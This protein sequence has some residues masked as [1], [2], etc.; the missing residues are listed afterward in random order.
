MRFKYTARDTKGGKSQ[1][2]IDAS[3]LKA[4]LASLREMG[5]LPI[6]IVAQGQGLDVMNLSFGKKNA[7]RKDVTNFTRQLATMITAGLPLTDALNLLKLQSSPAMSAIV[8]AILADVQGGVALSESMARHPEVFSTIYVA[9]IRAGEAGGV[10]ETVLNRLAENME[11]SREF[12]GKVKGAM[13]Y[14]VIVLAGMVAVMV[15]MMVFVVPKITTLYGEFNAQLPWSTKLVI[16]VS[17]FLIKFWWLAGMMVAGLVGGVRFLLNSPEG[18]TW[19][20]GIFYRIPVAGTL[21]KEMML[22][23]LTRT[24]SLLIGAGVAIVDALTISAGAVG[25]VVT[26]RAV[27]AIAKQV[28]RGFPVSISFSESPI[29]PSIL[30]QILA[31]GEETGKMDEVLIK[32][33]HYFEMDA[34]EKVKGLT[35]AIEP[36]IIILLAVGVGFLMFAIIMPIYGITDKI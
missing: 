7:S 14:P 5:F 11:K 25:N 17:N 23:E 18:R 4:A 21:A 26:E 33:S 22:T 34:E 8:T 16:G 20:D 35:S 31:V 28:E 13:V 24:L 29:F 19:W 15:L 10:V 6:N 32:L 36:L 2:T 27:K 30:G 12:T 9:L 1:G 3:D